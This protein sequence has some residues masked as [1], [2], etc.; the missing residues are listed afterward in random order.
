MGLSLCL[1]Q[2]T[3]AQSPKLSPYASISLI[4]VSP[5]TEL[6]S[7][8]GHSALWVADPANGIDRVY[9][10]GTFDF[11]TEGF[12]VKFLR[13][14]LPYQLSVGEL[15]RTL[16]GAQLEGRSVREQ[17]LNLSL[18]QRQRLFD[19]LEDNYR[20]EKREYWY[21]FF[22]D[23]CSSRLRDALEASLGDSVRF[24]PYLLQ[25]QR[26][27]SYRDWIGQYSATTK[28]W[29]DFGMS[30]AIGQPADH[31]VTDREA[32][33]LPDNLSTAFDKA[34][35]KA[36]SQWRPLAVAA[37][38]LYA[39]SEIAEERSSLPHPAVLMWLLC[40]LGGV[41]T[42]YQFWK[43]SNSLA[44]DKVLLGVVGLAGWLLT[45][46]WVG[47]D[48]GVT[49]Q[50]WNLLWAIPLYVP[51]IWL[52]KASQPQRWTWYFYV[53]CLA[54][55]VFTLIAWVWLPQGL[56]AAALPIVLLLTMRVGRLVMLLK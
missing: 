48:H 13:G 30:L 53:A 39:P 18:S 35:V 32:M 7:G 40:G 20:P 46:L 45:F 54:L 15:E 25:A 41:L 52:T 1:W 29:S 31:V 22:Y 43:K 28:P 47:T 55:L 9:N 12:Y 11:R 2:N 50:N 17:V 19:F 6:Y 8:F 24:N 10:Y 4:T 16:Y 49:A 34:S 3:Q 37:R 33:F 36:D 38:T 26:T 21:K 27:F 5:G 14:T 56:P 23:N 51:I 44:F 42:A